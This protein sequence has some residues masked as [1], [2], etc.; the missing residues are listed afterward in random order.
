MIDSIAAAT[1]GFAGADLQALATA[2]VMAAVGRA[3]PDLVDSLV[4]DMNLQKR[5]GAAGPKL[6]ASEALKGVK[7]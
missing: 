2:A 5:T 1:D 4:T 3:A 7:V 6:G